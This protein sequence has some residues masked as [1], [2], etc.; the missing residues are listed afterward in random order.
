MAQF[1]SALSATALVF[2]WLPAITALVITGFFSA[3]GYSFGLVFLILGL[4][5]SVGCIGALNY[6]R[7]FS[8]HWYMGLPLAAALITGTVC[9]FLAVTVIPALATPGGF[10]G[11]LIT[12]SGTVALLCLAPCSI[13]LFVSLSS[14][15]ERNDLI[16]TALVSGFVSLVS[17]AMLLDKAFFALNLSAQEMFRHP[18][19]EAMMIFYGMGT[20]IIGILLLMVVRRLP[21]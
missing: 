15:G 6:L 21:E 9:A 20:T 2:F 1:R 17:A 3:I 8:R 19:G 10:P 5:S 7:R 11:M 13:L 18:M 14:V 4:I 12:G 16:A